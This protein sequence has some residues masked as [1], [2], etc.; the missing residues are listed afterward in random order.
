MPRFSQS[1]LARLATC[2]PALRE[3]FESV[4][5]EYDHTVLEGHRDQAAQDAA[6]ARG[7]SKLRWPH[8]KHNA[9]PSRAVDV[10]PY[11]VD[12]GDRGTPEERRR[13]IERFYRFA[14]YVRG[15]AHG[16]GIAI[17]WGGDWDGDWNFDE[18]RFRDLVHFEL[19]DPDAGPA[20][21]RPEEI[22]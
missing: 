2:H 22:A 17:R 8:G 21:A 14:H 7:A 10:A 11:P 20:I 15:V 4:I 6:F 1:S 13:A 16:K 3:L 5:E 19:V 12:F 18:E 9:S